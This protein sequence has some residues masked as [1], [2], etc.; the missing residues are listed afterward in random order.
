MVTSTLETWP[1]SAARA[2]ATEIDEKLD[3]VALFRVLFEYR[4]TLLLCGV[5][6]G[7]VAA[8]YALL[9][10]PIF[11]AEVTVT[12]VHEK[13]QGSGGGLAGQLG[14]IAS[15]A[16]VNIGEQSDEMAAKAVLSSRHLIEVFIERYGVLPALQ[17]KQKAPLTLWKGVNRF[18]DGVLSIRE[19]S[20]KGVTII[21]INWTDPAVAARWANDFV[22]LAN[23]LIRTKALNDARRNVDYLTAQVSGTSSVEIQRALYG[24]V[25]SETKKLMLANERTEYAFSVADP[26]VTP[27]IR[28]S[29][30]RTLLVLFGTGIGLFIGASIAFVRAR[31]AAR[32]A[33]PVTAT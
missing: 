1:R 26:A 25:M 10:T 9:A 2:G 22:A 7:A 18:H 19:D 11:R 14:D 13:D 17:G 23:E 8:T 5:L 4:W 29:P 6:F 3:V 15:L 30:K 28:S 24:L 20:R 27:E 21:G 12:P 33:E 32:R 16:G 31:L